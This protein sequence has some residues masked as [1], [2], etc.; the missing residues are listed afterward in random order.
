MTE[1]LVRVNTK[2]IELSLELQE[3][4]RKLNII[5]HPEVNNIEEVTSV[6]SDYLLGKI[7]KDEIEDAI[8]CIYSDIH[9][10]TDIKE[11]ILLG[12]SLDD[13]QLSFLRTHSIL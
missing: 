5:E 8:Q 9:F 3:L 7:D 4:D 11:T 13:T 12:R 10:F 2:L 6:V 1:I